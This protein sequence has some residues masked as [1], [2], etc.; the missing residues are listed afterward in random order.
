MVQGRRPNPAAAPT[1]N[2][3]SARAWPQYLALGYVPFDLD[4]NVRNANS[5]YGDPDA[6][7]GSAATTLEYAVDD[8]AI[9]QFAARSLGDRAHLPRL[10]A[11]APATGASSS[12][13]PAA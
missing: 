13:R 1:A 10:H 12:T 5:I 3:S 2:T 11:A 7:W 8:F 9:A 4:T 6:V